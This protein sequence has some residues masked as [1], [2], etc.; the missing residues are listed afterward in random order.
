MIYFYIMPIIF[1]I[2]YATIALEH[3][4]KIDKAATALVTGG[5]LWLILVVGHNELWGFIQSNEMKEFVGCAKEGHTDILTVITHGAFTEHL[6]DIASIIFFLL[7]AMTIVEVVDRYQGFRIITDKI[8]TTNKV[9]LLWIISWLAFFISAVL[10]NLTTTIVMVTLLQKLLSKQ[11][12]RW[13]FSGMVVIAANSGGA[14]SPMG[15]VT[16][17]MLWIGGQ[18]TA[19]GVVKGLFVPSLI[20]T[21][22]PLIILSIIMPGKTSKPMLDEDETEEFVPQ[23]YR[24]I[25]LILGLAA[26]VSV[27]I[28]KAT[29]H[30]PPSMGMLLGLGVLWVYTDLTLK[31][32]AE[33]L[34]HRKLSV[35]RILE[36]VDVATVMFFLG[37]LLSV[38]ALQVAGHLDL[39]ANWL[40]NSV[41]NVYAIDLIIGLLSSIVDNVPLVAAGMGMY[42]IAHVGA[43]GYAANFVVDGP[44]WEFLAYCAGTG[45]SILIIGSAAGVAAMGL[46]GIPFFWYLKKI[47]WLALIG[48]LSGAAFYILVGAI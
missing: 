1:V 12:N 48:Y 3:F 43:T 26:L 20:S 25:I 21:L 18:I 31:R 2:G 5:L 32:R 40:K 47:G 24:V 33:H 45:G 8:K 10:D 23:R 34:D 38:A 16:T 19:A 35:V 6:G 30:L 27:P 4:N 22:V 13:L 9:K 41:G 28:L 17:I 42:D 7:G 15:D 46:E 29:T 14:F 11:D 36:K 37:I 39:L 44:F